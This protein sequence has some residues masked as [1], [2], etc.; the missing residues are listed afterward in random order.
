[1]ET[2]SIG[3]HHFVLRPL[4]DI[5]YARMV[6]ALRDPEKSR[7]QVERE[8][9]LLAIEEPAVEEVAAIFSRS[10]AIKSLLL[11]ELRNLTG[12]SDPA[13]KG[14]VPE[15]ADLV[16][17]IGAQTYTLRRP[18]EDQ[19]DAFIALAAQTPA[20]AMANLVRDCAM[21]PSGEALEAALEARPGHMLI[22]AGHLQVLAGAGLEVVRGKPRPC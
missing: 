22:L 14:E 9:L 18:S 8:T 4:T 10:P 3:E 2:L 20:G 13:A 7:A 5:E 6:D 12:E 19:F 11:K 16:L 21:E 15:G 1:M 17:H